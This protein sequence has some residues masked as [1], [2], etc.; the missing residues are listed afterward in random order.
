MHRC[1]SPHSKLSSCGVNDSRLG[2]TMGL[3]A[4]TRLFKCR[5]WKGEEDVRNTR[6]TKIKTMKPRTPPL[7]P[8]FQVLPWAVAK[9]VSSAMA[10][11]TRRRVKRD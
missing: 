9:R 11:E 6:I 4:G 10:K 1:I 8:Y 7:V 5:K 2:G 3:P